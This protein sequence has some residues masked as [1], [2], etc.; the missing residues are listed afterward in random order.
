MDAD[1]FDL[2]PLRPA[3]AG[4]HHA[5]ENPL[6]QVHARL[7]GRYHWAAAIAALLAPVFAAAGWL[8]VKPQYQ[9]TGIV[10]VA[11]TL[12]RLLYESEENQLPP[13]F[14][15]YVAA[16]ATY[17]SSRRVLDKAA[18]PT[19]KPAALGDRSLSDLGWPVGADGVVELRNRLSVRLGASR[20]TQL[21]IVS[22]EHSEPDMAQHAVNAVLTAYETTYGEEGQV[23]TTS[24]ERI[25]Q[26][27]AQRL[28]RELRTTLDSIW[29][30]TEKQGP[31]TLDRLH[32]AKIRELE[33]I[34]GQVNAIE[35]MLVQAQ[36]AGDDPTSAS[37][38]SA[39]SILA[40]Q[41]PALADLVALRDQLRTEVARLGARFGPAHPEMRRRNGDLSAVQSRIDS[42]VAELE[43]DGAGAASGATASGDGAR[44][45]DMT[46]AQLATMLEQY[47]SIR[48][49]VFA[50]G[51]QLGERRQTIARLRDQ[52]AETRQLLDETRAALEALRVE[53]QASHSGRIS[54]AQ[55]GD[56]PLAPSTDRR[57][58]LAAAGAMAGVGLSL[59]V[60]F[61]YGLIDRR[62]RYIDE[63][64][65]R[66]AP[67]RLGALP[68]LA[69]A[70]EAQQELARFSVHQIRNAITSSVRTRDGARTLCVTSPMSGDGK[71]SLT[72]AL[73]MSFASGGDRTLI[74]DADLVGRGLTRSL[75]LTGKPGLRE[76]LE[77]RDV[78][79]ELLAPC[80]PSLEVLPTGVVSDF[81]PERVSAVRL[82]TLLASLRDRYDT[83]L[84]DTGPLLGSIE[85]DLASSL[86]DA[87]VLVIS[88]GQSQ[89]AVNDCFKRL[90]ETGRRCAG[91]VFNKADNGD[92]RRSSST[93]SQSLRSGT[94]RSPVASG[95]RRSL[96]DAV[97][98]NIR[99]GRLLVRMGRI[100]QEQ[101]D[102][103][104][105]IQSR[106]GES[107]GRILV[108]GGFVTDADVQEAL[109]SQQR[110]R[111]GANES[112][113]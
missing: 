65:L 51:E 39:E 85:A 77:G 58:P 45:A 64:P 29:R 101:L 70:D 1:P 11:P 49:R 16:Q 19:F 24:R 99:L 31:E 88:R 68:E 10:R 73:G 20:G 25:L 112:A 40:R 8:A 48:S 4:A 14:D 50:E 95:G 107:L 91:Y 63:I 26:D 30:I 12:P 106:S 18:D 15:S 62:Y 74:I 59:G 53:E 76:I 52:E 92:F 2:D 103:A 37:A 113:A 54:I 94:F 86:S 43:S 75:S 84:M 109:R 87:T 42:R 35:L 57:M 96:M 110:F 97:A 83:I 69:Q 22:V 46:P 47:R 61:L 41:D 72:L 78:T 3:S 98:A 21:I 34:D 105:E 23:A 81:E 36:Q 28:D 89:K 33:R 55:F 27:R 56:R 60:V 17:L 111:P 80:F 67:T 32:E 13:L 90:E 79:D 71:T 5:V 104:L 7:R 100:T 108:E 93:M 102:E 38:T 66:R 82:E 44:L 9:S 6:L